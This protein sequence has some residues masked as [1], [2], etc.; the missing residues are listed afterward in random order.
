M[1]ADKQMSDLPST[2][3]SLYKVFGVSEAH[4]VSSVLHNGGHHI[5]KDFI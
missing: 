3:P 1:L 4:G 5:V 2:A